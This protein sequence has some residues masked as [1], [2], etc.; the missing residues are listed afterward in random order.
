MV[1]K[2][3]DNDGI[4]QRLYH[5]LVDISPLICSGA[6]LVVVFSILVKIDIQS[7]G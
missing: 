5:S 3:L 4:S 2:R 6:F 1:E 7:N